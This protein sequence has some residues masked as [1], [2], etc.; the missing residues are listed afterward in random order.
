MRVTAVL[1]TLAALTAAGASLAGGA[2][3]GDRLRIAAFGTSLTAHGNWPDKLAERLSACTGAPASM[4]RIAQAGASTRWA[5]TAVPEVVAARPD[6][7]LIEFAHNDA[8][9]NRPISR[10]ASAANIATILTRL[11]EAL[12]AARVYVMGMNPVSGLRGALRPSL[13]SFIDAQRA[14]AEK[15][16]ARFVDH[17]PLWA[18]L[19]PDERDRAI[20]D[21]LHPTDE[22]ATLTMVPILARLI[23]GANC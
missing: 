7:V 15:H 9:L 13:D 10:S 8:A 18:A 11:R 19:R 5:L 20:P 16:G 14:I 3:G 23:G 22:A 12:P 4:T 21:G 1:L 2:A 17:R 6:V